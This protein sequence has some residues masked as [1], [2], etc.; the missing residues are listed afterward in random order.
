MRR[1][2]LTADKL[3]RATSRRVFAGKLKPKQVIP[4]KKHREPRYKENFLPC[5][6]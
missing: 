2:V 6:S 5:D 3:V 1:K 4:N